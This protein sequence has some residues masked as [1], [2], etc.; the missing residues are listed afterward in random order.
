[1][2]TYITTP[3]SI[4]LVPSPLYV[5]SARPNTKMKFE[6]CWTLLSGVL[7]FNFDFYILTF[8]L[9]LVCTS[10]IFR[11]SCLDQLPYYIFFKKKPIMN[12]K[13]KNHWFWN[14]RNSLKNPKSI[15]FKYDLRFIKFTNNVWGRVQFSSSRDTPFRQSEAEGL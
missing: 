1:M 4:T 11:L 3:D 7:I 6:I 12:E 5:F 8:W 14:Y 15:L 2:E 10:L 9:L 13:A